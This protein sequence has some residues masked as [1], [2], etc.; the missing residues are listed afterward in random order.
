ME[1]GNTRSGPYT[2]DRE[3]TASR[4]SAT[5]RVLVIED[6]VDAAESLRE[7]L[8]LDGHTV[9]IAHSGQDGVAKSLTFRPDLVLCDIGLPGMDGYEVA[10]RLRAERKLASPYLVALTGYGLPEDLAKAKEAGFDEHIAKPASLERIA[11]L[12][13]NA[14]ERAARS[15]R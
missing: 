4:A 6:N 2:L 10:R 15:K 3:S 12:L 7:A 13:A 8:E 1:N 9:E 5:R 11:R 14:S